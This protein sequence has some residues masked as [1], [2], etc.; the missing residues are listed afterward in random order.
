MSLGPTYPEFNH[1]SGVMTLSASPVS[2]DAPTPFH[3]LS[4]LRF[5]PGLRLTAMQFTL[6]CA[7]HSESV[8][9]LVP[10]GQVLAMSPT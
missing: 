4:P 1:R 9:E 3:A 8:L 10:D 6:L 5:P 2:L 7:E